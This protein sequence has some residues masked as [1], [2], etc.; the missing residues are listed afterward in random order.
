MADLLANFPGTSDFSLPQQEVLV[1]EEQE[2]L[3]HFD[4]SFTSQGGNRSGIEVTR[5][6][7]RLLTSYVSPAL[8]MKQSMKPC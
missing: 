4:G 1:T 7:T 5:G 8:I 3:M 6:G 2:W